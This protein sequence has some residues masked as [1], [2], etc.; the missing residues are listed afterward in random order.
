MVIKEKIPITF[1]EKM[2]GAVDILY[3]QFF[4]DNAPN[5]TELNK[6]LDTNAQRAVWVKNRDNEGLKKLLKMNEALKKTHELKLRHLQKEMDVIKGLADDLEIKKDKRGINDIIKGEE[7]WEFLDSCYM[8]NTPHYTDEEGKIQPL[9]SHKERKD[10]DRMF[11]TFHRFNKYGKKTF[12]IE[13]QLTH[14]LFLTDV[15]N[16]DSAF[17][18]FPFPSICFYLPFNNKLCIRKEIIRYVYI[19]ER[20][21]VGGENDNVRIL[22]FLYIT[23][24]E[25]IEVQQFEIGD[26]Q[27]VEQITNQIADIFNSPLGQKEASGISSFILAAI[28]YLNS[29]EVDERKVFPIFWHKNHD[30]RFP[31]C[32]LGYNIS[33]DKGLHYSQ[34]QETAGL[35]KPMNVLKW[36]VRGHFR[37]YRKGEHWKEDRT[38][39]IRPFIKGKERDNGDQI[40]KPT[41]YLVQ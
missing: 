36:T 13:E 6:R 14:E 18:K 27:F 39:W 8:S 16:V 33:I 35:G 31:V 10:I 38:I 22:E 17:L 26:G 19:S 30:S 12:R 9:N 11:W 5:I 21:R 25:N 23:D 1:F 7:A 24:K 15:N 40:I 28:L 20:V 37:A 34:N 2:K 41:N 4:S 32:S 3:P 29:S